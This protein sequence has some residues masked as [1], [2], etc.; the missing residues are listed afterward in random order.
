MFGKVTF[1]EHVNVVEMYCKGDISYMFKR[2]SFQFLHSER[3]F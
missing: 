2:L 1:N 3:N